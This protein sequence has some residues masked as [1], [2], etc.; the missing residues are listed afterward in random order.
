MTHRSCHTHMHVHAHFLG[1]S[2]VFSSFE[3]SLFDF[4]LDIVHVVLISDGYHR[5]DEWCEIVVY[6]YVRLSRCRLV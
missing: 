3:V 1:L 2:I 6:C 4:S 5:R